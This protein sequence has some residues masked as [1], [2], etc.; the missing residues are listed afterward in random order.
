MSGDT[1]VLSDV[2]ALV[3]NLGMLAF[4]RC[5][6]PVRGGGGRW[7]I[8]K[9]SSKEWKLTNIEIENVHKIIQQ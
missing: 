6:A 7:H 1:F 4:K 8:K 2:N 5:L 3:P 9:K